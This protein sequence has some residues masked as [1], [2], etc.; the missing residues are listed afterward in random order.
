MFYIAFI[1]DVKYLVF[2]PNFTIDAYTVA[3]QYA[4]LVKTQ[5]EVPSWLTALVSTSARLP[6]W[7]QFVQK[8][9]QCNVLDYDYY[10][11]LRSNLAEIETKQQQPEMLSV[12]NTVELLY[13]AEKK[14][15]QQ[16]DVLSISI[17]KSFDNQPEPFSINLPAVE[18]RK[19]I[20]LDRNAIIGLSAKIT[21]E[22]VYAACGVKKDSILL[23]SEASTSLKNSRKTAMTQFVTSK[24]Y[25]NRHNIRINDLITFMPSLLASAIKLIQQHNMDPM[26]FALLTKF[27]LAH[28][29]K[30]HNELRY[31]PY[32]V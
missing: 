25:I 26:E 28:Y 8:Q 10:I 2:D 18:P 29:I 15:L 17:M 31:V 13:V 19:D 23:M 9:H 20:E 16:V 4:Y 11:S 21:V 22:A 27:E 14:P 1:A 6:F 12:T 32:R 3:K 30:C 5:Q 24:P 7:R